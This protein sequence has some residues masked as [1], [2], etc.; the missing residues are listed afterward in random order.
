M[1]YTVKNV[2]TVAAQPGWYDVGY[3]STDATL[4]N[5]DQSNTYLN[6]QNSVLAAGASY[7]VNA[8]FT[9]ST[10]T[11]AGSYTFFVKADGHNASYTG[12][13]NTDTGNLS[14]SNEANNTASATVVLSKPDLTVGPLTVGTIV[15]N[16]N[17]S[18]TI[19][20]TYT[21]KNVGTIT[22]QP[23]WYDVGYLST[24]ATL[25]NTDQSNGYLNY[26]GG[27]LAAGASYTVNASFT[28]STSTAA[29]TYTFFV[30][31]DGH[32]AAYTG[33]TNTDTGNLSESNETNNVAAA[34]VV[35]H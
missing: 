2:G 16:Q 7:T 14:E 24:D 9:T 34:T 25:D 20:V 23:G 18:W 11:A 33:G 26:Q 31:A 17:G 4:D 12:G 5:S 6:T 8:S 21:V 29:G 30:K 3:L 32:N 13:T 10:A 28:T 1:T 15:A 35:L 27:P 19:P 22:A